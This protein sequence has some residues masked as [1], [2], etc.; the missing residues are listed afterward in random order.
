MQVSGLH[1][2][3]EHQMT[4]KEYRALGHETLSPARL[5]QLRR[6]PV[7]QGRVKHHSGHEHP[8]YKG[9]HV[10]GQ[11][12]R[13]MFVQGRRIPEHRYVMEQALGRPLE[14][15]E[16][17]HHIDG[18]KQNNRPENLQVMS[19]GEHNRLEDASRAYYHIFPETIE[20]AKSLFAANWNVSRISR[21]LRV[22]EATVRR[23]LEEPL[24]H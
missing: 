13:I 16:V 19:Q 18:D 9:G 7:A 11:G 23:W 5:A 24:A 6:T 10:N 1:L 14:R 21:A 8:R 2:R 17:V 20:A 15:S 4:T 3:V 22:H 12:Y